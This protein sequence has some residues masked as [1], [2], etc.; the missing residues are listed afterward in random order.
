MD[1]PERIRTRRLPRHKDTTLQP[2]TR[3]RRPLDT[4]T[5]RR[6]AGTM[7]SYPEG[8]KDRP[9]KEL[10]PHTPRMECCL[11]MEVSG[12][13]DCV[14]GHRGTLSQLILADQSAEMDPGLR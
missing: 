4:E 13:E 2:A 5:R 14:L 9:G 3:N 7:H 8:N 12:L 6:D 10:I 1:E 11:N